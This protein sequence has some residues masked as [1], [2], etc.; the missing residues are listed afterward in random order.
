VKSAPLETS[1]PNEIQHSWTAMGSISPSETKEAQLNKKKFNG[2]RVSQGKWGK[3]F[4]RQA[5]H[6]LARLTFFQL[7]GEPRFNRASG[8][9][10]DESFFLS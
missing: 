1:S 3:Y 9:R 10:I 7:T 4:T 8:G 6:R 5:P 2:P